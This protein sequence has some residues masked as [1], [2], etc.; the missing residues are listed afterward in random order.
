MTSVLSCLV[1]TIAL[2]AD[3]GLKGL[4]LGVPPAPDDAVIAHVAPPQCLFYVN[5]AGTASPS[6]SSASE[7]EK[8]LAEPEVQ[9]FFNGLNKVIVG[10][11]R[12]SDEAAKEKKTAVPAP[13]PKT[14]EPNAG[15]DGT[16]GT[17]ATYGTNV[18]YGTGAKAAE[19]APPAA[20]TTMTESIKVSGIPGIEAAPPAAT[21]RIE[22][23]PAN[24][25]PFPPGGAP[26]GTS[27]T[28]PPTGYDPFAPPAGA[29]EPALPSPAECLPGYNPFAP[30]AVA[31]RPP[32]RC[33][34]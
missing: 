13:L 22:P 25:D 9:E 10:Y 16:Y 30:P 12:K 3:P 14:A 17:N 6:A 20:T 5:W 31:P 11:L 2:A 26:P 19:P 32:R 7:T 8:L 29:P 24:W 21:A 1:A 18:T 33:P 4:P 28:P 34:G 15:E 27:Y 23:P